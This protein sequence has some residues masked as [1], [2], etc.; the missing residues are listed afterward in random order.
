MKRTTVWSLIDT[1]ICMHYS[2]PKHPASEFT[3]LGVQSITRFENRTEGRGFLLAATL[4]NI[5]MI[6]KECGFLTH[7]YFLLFVLCQKLQFIKLNRAIKKAINIHS[8]CIDANP[9]YYIESMKRRLK[10]D[11]F[12]NF[13]YAH[14][15]QTRPG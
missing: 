11:F 12:K 13:R 1:I 14:V 7:Y 5:Q 9:R 6:L 10:L 15:D 2:C 3:R 8:R 4:L